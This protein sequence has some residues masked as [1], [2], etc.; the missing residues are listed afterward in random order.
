MRSIASHA[1]QAEAPQ[2]V[3][4]SISAADRRSW[5]EAAGMRR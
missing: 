2:L 1:C 3:R 5:L 4:C